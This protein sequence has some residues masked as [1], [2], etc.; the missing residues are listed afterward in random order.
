[1]LQNEDDIESKGDECQTELQWI[2]SEPAPVLLKTA[3]DDQ[4]H[5]TE[6]ATSEVKQLLDD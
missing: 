4:L 2:A 6:H 1:M 5:Q 3:V